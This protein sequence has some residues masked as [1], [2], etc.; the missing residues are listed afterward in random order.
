MKV[1]I[2]GRKSVTACP[3][4]FD[5]ASSKKTTSARPKRHEKR[6][7][8][9]SEHEA[10]AKKH[11]TKKLDFKNATDKRELDVNKIHHDLS[12]LCRQ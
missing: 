1:S 11:C 2:S 3:I 12:Y 7:M 9:R 10:S 5:P 8:E 4:I 6:Q